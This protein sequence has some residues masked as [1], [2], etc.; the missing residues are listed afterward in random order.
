MGYRAAQES[1]TRIPS[2]ISP[3]ASTASSTARRPRHR[4][5]LRKSRTRAFSGSSPPVA[6]RLRPRARCLL[7]LWLALL[8]RSLHAAVHN[9]NATGQP[10]SSGTQV[11]VVL[12]KHRDRGD[13]DV[14]RRTVRGATVLWDSVWSYRSS[15]RCSRRR[16]SDS[17]HLPT[18]L[19]RLR[20]SDVSFLDWRSPGDRQKYDALEARH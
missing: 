5:Q 3:L 9:Q 19:C 16:A 17:C 15:A 8:V 20:S 1:Q 6:L 13:C 7:S 11:T 14:A 10:N 12:E 18:E 4:A 2:K